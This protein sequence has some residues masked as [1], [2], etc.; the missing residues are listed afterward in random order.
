MA[1]YQPEKLKAQDIKDKIAEKYGS[2][3]A[4]AHQQLLKREPSINGTT[5]ESVSTLSMKTGAI[6]TV[7]YTDIFNK[8]KQYVLIVNSLN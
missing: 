2:T 6:I 1:I 7:S 3:F 4:E 8:I 5:I